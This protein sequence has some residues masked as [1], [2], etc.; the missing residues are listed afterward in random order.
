MT[1][2]TA[3]VSVVVAKTIVV[4]AGHVAGVDIVAFAV[5]GAA[6]AV[7]AARYPHSSSLALP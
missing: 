4:A 3:V 5:V 2:V 7:A 6:V 1:V